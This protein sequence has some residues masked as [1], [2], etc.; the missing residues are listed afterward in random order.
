MAHV[1]LTTKVTGIAL[2]FKNTKIIIPEKH[3]YVKI[4][5]YRCKQ[6]RVFRDNKKEGY[7]DNGDYHAKNKPSI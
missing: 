1:A 7:W 2:Q 5:S 3:L 6:I 4:P